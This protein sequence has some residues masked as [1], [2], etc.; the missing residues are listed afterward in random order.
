[1]RF[2]VKVSMPVVKGNDR[3]KD[4]SLPKAIKGILDDLKPEAVYFTEE[5]GDRAMLLVVN[6]NDPSEMVRIAEPSFLAFEAS[7]EFHPVMALEDLMKAMPD[8]ER[9]VKK[10]G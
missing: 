5:Y 8:M 10:Y 2:L 4:G 7:V 6:M 9:A 3:I 1:M